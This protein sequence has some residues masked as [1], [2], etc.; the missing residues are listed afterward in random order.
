MTEE[1]ALLTA[2]AANPDEDTPRLAYADWLDEHDRPTR[3]ELI[4]VQCAISAL[5]AASIPVRNANVHLWRR[6]QDL[7]EFHREEL[8]GPLNKSLDQ[9]GAFFERGF[10]RDVT[11]DAEAFLQH[12][13]TLASLQPRPSIGVTDAHRCLLRLARSPEA[14]VING[15]TMSNLYDQA[16][17][18]GDEFAH[19]AHACKSWQLRTLDLNSSGLGD[20][21]V[22]LLTENDRI[23]WPL[24]HL[25]LS[26]N[27]VTDDGI[28][29][30]T[31]SSLF[32]RLKS[33]VLR[34]TP[35]TDEAA[36]LL[37]TTPGQLENLNVANTNITSEGQ[38]VLLC[39]EG[40]KIDLY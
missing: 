35:I 30:L 27:P 18:P 39:R 7:L 8:L 22:G 15:L 20:S 24:S 23:D 2:I 34:S 28:R 5:D 33:L 4:R 19:F 14:A 6:Q 32:P 17:I 16:T 26:M 37:A 40:T 38:Q 21:E 9:W 12:A 13:T 1:D 25:D 36:Q 11:I 31:S 29:T 3:A 10:L